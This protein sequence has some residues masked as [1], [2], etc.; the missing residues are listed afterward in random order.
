MTFTSAGELGAITYGNAWRSKDRRNIYTRDA[1]GRI[2][3][4]DVPLHDAV[5]IRIEDNVIPQAETL[6]LEYF[7][8]ELQFRLKSGMWR[9]DQ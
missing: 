5:Q 3:T 8:H 6:V 4:V 7:T 9:A 1:N 2:V